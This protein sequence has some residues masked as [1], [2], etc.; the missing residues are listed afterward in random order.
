MPFV[1]PYIPS[2]QSDYD[3]WLANFEGLIA[4]TP[5]AYGLTA[6]EAG[7]ITA[8]YAAWHAAYLLV[9]S[10]A[11]KTATTVAAKDVERL[12]SLAVARVYAVKISLNPGVTVYDKIAVGVNPRTSVPSPI[13]APVTAPDVSVQSAIPLTLYMRFRDPITAPKV[14]AKPYGVTRCQLFGMT[15]ATAIVDP[16]LLPWVLDATKSPFD[17][18]F[19]A[20]AAGKRF[21]YS[22][23]WV[24]RTGLASP[25]SAVGSFIV[26]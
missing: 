10:P 25:F 2:K 17:L 19:D 14:K 12:L 9:T 3:T 23:R 5:A 18:S 6:G 1:Q 24:V 4:A 13:L 20:A 22:G 26:P 16:L 8:A 7:S 15:S 11:T 21:Y